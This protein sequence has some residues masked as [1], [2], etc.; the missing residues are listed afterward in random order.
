MGLHSLLRAYPYTFTCRLY[1]F[2]TGNMPK[3]PH[4]LLRRY[5]Y[6]FYMQTMLAPHRK[7]AYGPPRPF[8]EIALLLYMQMT[9]IPYRKHAHGPPRAV[10]GIALSLQGSVT[11]ATE[12]GPL[13]QLLPFVWP[14]FLD[15]MTDTLVSSHVRED[16]PVITWIWRQG[17]VFYSCVPYPATRQPGKLSTA[18]VCCRNVT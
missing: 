1:P 13:L 4:G 5:L 14:N 2:F 11:T 12:V 3:G 18:D 7:H 15:I 10:T 8:T 16:S 6:F 9:F 17:N